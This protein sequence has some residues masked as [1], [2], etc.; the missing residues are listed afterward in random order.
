MARILYNRIRNRLDDA[1]SEDQYGF[2][3]G[4]STTHAL[5]V[6]ESIISKSIEYDMPVWIVSVDLRK[7]FD[8]VEHAALFEA[9]TQQMD[10]LEYV[11]LLKL[12]YKE[13]IGIIE[14]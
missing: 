2:R 3:K 13:Q 1:Q 12:L 8:R 6:L 7:A 10:D 4:R 9:L 11:A 14:S 5:I